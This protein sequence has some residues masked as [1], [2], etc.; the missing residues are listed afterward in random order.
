MT[1]PSSSTVTELVLVKVSSAEFNRDGVLI[2]VSRCETKYVCVEDT[3]DCVCVCDKT[4]F[5]YPLDVCQLRKTCEKREASTVC[6]AKG[7]CRW[8]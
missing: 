3:S 8:V 5:V 4:L 6:G 7:T 1:T 2:K